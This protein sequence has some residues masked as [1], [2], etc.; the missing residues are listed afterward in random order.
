MR[1]RAQFLGV[2]VSA[3]VALAAQ[4]QTAAVTANKV[5]IH[6][7]GPMSKGPLVASN[8]EGI[9]GAQAY[10]EQINKQGGVNGRQLEMVLVDDQQEPALADKLSKEIVER[11]EALA[12]FLPRTSPTNQALMK[13]LTPAGIPLVAPQ[14]GPNFLYDPKQTTAYLTRASYEAELLRA[15]ELQLKFDR[16]SFA[17]LAADDA[18]GNPLVAAATSKLA[19]LNVKPIVQ[20]VD[21]RAADIKPA[22]DAFAAIKPEV[23]F[24]LCS[25][26]CAA[27]FVNDYRS[28]GLTA[29]FIALSNNSSNLFVKALGANGRGVI[30]MQVT[31]LPTSRTI[32][33]SREYQ[34]LCAQAKLDASYSGFVGYIGAR[35]LVEGVRR[36]GKNLTPA[37]LKTAFES[38]RN[39]DLGDFA[40]SFGPTD[41][42][43]TDFVDET[44]ISKDGKF[45]R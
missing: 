6:H 14:V 27:D 2:I 7:M 18:F 39:Y 4:A 45:L 19:P 37:T 40:I 29:Q 16:K 42:I 20:K 25:A 11:N 5:R 15:L 10:F 32:R 43:G 35:V 26:K 1:I 8:K 12:F 36:A 9:A 30:V 44:I 34:A 23:V 28:R 21:N 24:L 13:N 38:M 41:R 17:F 3:C 31:P 33:I 22:L